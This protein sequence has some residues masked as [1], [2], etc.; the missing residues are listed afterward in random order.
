YLFS[1]Q[2]PDIMAAPHE[3][4]LLK[5]EPDEAN[6]GAGLDPGDGSGDREHPGDAAAVV[7]CARRAQGGIVMSAHKDNPGGVAVCASAVSD[8]VIGR[9]AVVA[10]RVPRHGVAGGGELPGY[11][12]SDGGEPARLPSVVARA[13]HEVEVRRERAARDGLDGGGDDR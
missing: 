6:G 3:A 1:R 8:D 7:V 9:R 12:I 4:E 5:R 2:A 13:H 11:I 10:H